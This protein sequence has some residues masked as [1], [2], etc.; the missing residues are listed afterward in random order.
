MSRAVSRSLE[1]AKGLFGSPSVSRHI[2]TKDILCSMISLTFVSTISLTVFRTIWRVAIE[3][4]G[5]LR[6]SEVSQL[7]FSDITWTDL[8]FDIFIK[9]S[10]TDQ[11]CKG[12]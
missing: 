2:I 9:K 6:Y 1:G 7:L 3:F 4:Y 10:K 5:L 12:D 8:G 11:T